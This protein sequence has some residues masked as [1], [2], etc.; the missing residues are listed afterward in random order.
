MVTVF[1]WAWRQIWRRGGYLSADLRLVVERVQAR[2]DA[3]VLGVFGGDEKVAPLGADLE[4]PLAPLLVKRDV[5]ELRVVECTKTLRKD[6]GISLV[7][8]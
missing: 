3:R 1:S 4:K 8:V 5:L 6:W 2:D 7:G